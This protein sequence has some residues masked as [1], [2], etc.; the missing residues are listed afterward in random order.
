MPLSL[1]V[2]G[3]NSAER[4]ELMSALRVKAEAL[5]CSWT[6]FLAPDEFPEKPDALLYC[7]QR[8]DGRK[9]AAR[10]AKLGALPIGALLA[11]NAAPSEVPLFTRMPFVPQDVADTLN[12]AA[13]RIR[14]S[15]PSESL[16]APKNASE[17]RVELQF[18]FKNHQRVHSLALCL[19]A[20]FQN[21]G[22]T[23]FLKLRSKGPEPREIWCWP[24][25]E[26]YWSAQAEESI[27]LD[28]ESVYEVFNCSGKKAALL[29]KAAELRP[30]SALLWRVGAKAFKTA[31]TLPWFA[32]DGKL[33]LARWPDI[34][35]DCRSM[36]LIRILARLTRCETSFVDLL[37]E[38]RLGRKDLCSAVNGLIMTGCMQKVKE[39]T[40]QRLAAEAMDPEEA[41][42]L[43]ALALR[44]TESL[45]EALEHLTGD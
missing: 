31:E 41:L 33:S 11:Q 44:C 14:L 17:E 9:W 12:V 2:A 29:E 42:F 38:L 37:T 45:E 1:A 6:I 19:F 30:S 15:E 4:A 40:R 32:L 3:L 28:S 22:K 35:K 24:D 34:P 5:S 10:L 8:E 25:L 26:L 16:A 39:P 23:Q 43:K 36:Q 20:V 18:S 13:K 27:A 7:P 21:S